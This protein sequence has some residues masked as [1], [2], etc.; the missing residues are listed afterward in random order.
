MDKESEIE[1]VERMKW[2]FSHSFDTVSLDDFN[3]LFDHARRG[4]AVPA[5]DAV[6]QHKKR[7]GEYRVEAFGKVQ[8]DVPLVDY[9]DVVVYRGKDGKVW[10]RP[11]GEFYDGRFEPLPPPG[12][13]EA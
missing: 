1:F 6:W 12:E 10:V 7:G 5:S 2:L 8:T 3:R 13:A 11:Y 4:A 9:A